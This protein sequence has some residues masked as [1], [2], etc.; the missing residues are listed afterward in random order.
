MSD[1]QEKQNVA[2]EMIIS[3]K[4][5]VFDSENDSKHTLMGIHTRIVDTHN[6]PTK[7]LTRTQLYL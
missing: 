4:S 5:V 2:T 7:Y 6:E 1:H 3:H